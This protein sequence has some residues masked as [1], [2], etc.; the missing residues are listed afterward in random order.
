MLFAKHLGSLHLKYHQIK[1]YSD[2]FD[3]FLKDRFNTDIEK[4][5]NRLFLS[6]SVPHT[7]LRQILDTVDSF[8]IKKDANQFFFTSKDVH[9]TMVLWS[10]E[11]DNLT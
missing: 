3:W 9:R 10:L 6:S 11:I 8:W 4:H 1:Y 2:R 7:F 5:L